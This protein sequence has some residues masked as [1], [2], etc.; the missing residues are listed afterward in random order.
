MWTNYRMLLSTFTSC[1]VVAIVFLTAGTNSF[2]PVR[3]CRRDT[4][5]SWIV[6]K[7]NISGPRQLLLSSSSVTNL[8]SNI[9]E[10]SNEKKKE[11]NNDDQTTTTTTTTTASTK[12]TN[13]D[14]NNNNNNLSMPWSDIQDWALRDNL[15][16]YIRMIS[17]KQEQEHNDDDDDD[18]KEILQLCCLWR[19]MMNDV[20]EI[21]GYPVTTLQ[22]IHKKQIENNITTIRTIPTLLPYLDDYQFTTSGGVIGYVYGIP[23]LADGTK[24]ETSPVSQVQV[25]LPKGYIRTIDGLAAYELGRPV[26]EESSSSSFSST[27]TTTTTDRILEEG[28]TLLSSVS[29]NVA[30]KTT[31]TMKDMEED[32]SDQMLV[33]LGATTGILLAGALAVS[34]LSHHL[35]VNVFWV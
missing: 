29:K 14:N 25:T 13:S 35:T 32:N 6:D 31:T 9:M 17:L 34:M 20:I 12:I 23:G 5:A 11:V 1:A 28:G 8:E 22:Q 4:T 24:I 7:C 30:L 19:T 21:A 18:E 27:T 26:K 15:P 10:N 3:K 33:R 2:M 16:K